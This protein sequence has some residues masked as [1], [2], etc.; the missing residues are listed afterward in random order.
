MKFALLDID[1]D[2]FH[3]AQGIAASA[4]HEITTC[5][6]PGNY[7]E[8]INGLAPHSTIA[9]GWESLLLENLVDVVVVGRSDTA[10][11]RS[12]KIKKL[13]QARVP[14]LVVHPACEAIVGYEIEMIRRDVGST[15]IP[16][17]PGI[18]SRTT[19]ELAATVATA[20][21]GQVEQ[22]TFER[23]LVERSRVHVLTQ[24]ARDVAIVREIVGPIKSVGAIGS[25]DDRTAPVTLSVSMAAESGCLA[26]WSLDPSAGES[27]G[28][29]TLLGRNGKVVCVMPARG[30][31]HSHWQSDQS[32]DLHDDRA[33]EVER[34]LTA[35]STTGEKVSHPLPAWVEACRA[36]EVVDTIP[37]CL[38]RGKTIDLYNEEHTEEG[39]FKGVMA[40]GG[41]LILMLGLLALFGI[42]IIEGLRLPLYRFSVWSNWPLYICAIFSFFLLL[43]LLR[44][45]ARD[46]R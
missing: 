5:Y 18:A 32:T 25:L 21:I 45:V 40:V 34:L 42:A 28:R 8:A 27:E 39:A 41:C 11:S 24:L 7:G 3:I 46:R 26:R 1:E 29:L 43:Q 31:W 22:L 17:Y 44:F 20:A 16:Y 36:Q 38:A 2:V 12:D 14:L 23:R 6:N 37:R 4:E 19:R 10:E 15:L 30:D 33:G 13:V 9:S 35:F